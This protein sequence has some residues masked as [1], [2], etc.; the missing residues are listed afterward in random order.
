MLQ[1]LKHAVEKKNQNYSIVEKCKQLWP[2]ALVA[3]IS[4]GCQANQVN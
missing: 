1:K 3:L 2:C 4:S